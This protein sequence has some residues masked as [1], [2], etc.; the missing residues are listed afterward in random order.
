MGTTAAGAGGGDRAQ[1]GGANGRRTA[2]V[3]TEAMN[4][5]TVGVQTNVAVRAGREGS[6]TELEAH[7]ARDKQI[8]GLD[9]AV[10][11]PLEVQVLHLPAARVAPWRTRAAAA[12]HL[13]RVWVLPDLRRGLGPPQPASAPGLRSTLPAPHLFRDS[14]RSRTASTRSRKS[15]HA[16]PS[17]SPSSTCRRR[18]VEEI[19]GGRFRRFGAALG[20][21][22]LK[23]SMHDCIST[24][25]S[26]RYISSA[27]ARAAAPV[28]CS[29]VRGPTAVRAPLRSRHSAFS[30]AA[31]TLLQRTHRL[32]RA[33]RTACR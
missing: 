16:K 28:P 10:D 32:R 15:R 13:Q 20:R 9:V 19:R 4:D 29:H 33:V 1:K 14:Q 27:A 26:M 12:S 8:L 2:R 11:D 23:T 31:L 18:R 17:S 7:V 24:Y 5:T 30:A 21:T 22:W 6:P 25:S 3:L